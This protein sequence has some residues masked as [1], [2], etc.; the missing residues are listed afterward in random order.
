MRTKYVLMI[1]LLVMLFPSCSQMDLAPEDWYGSNNFWNNEAQVKG[2]IY[3]I[4]KQ[5]RDG[6][7]NYWLMG[8]VRG[9]TLK[10]GTGVSTTSVSMNYVSPFI[11]QGFT[12]DKPGITSWGGFYGRILNVNL[13]IQKVENEC[14]FLTQANR[15]YYLGQ[16]Y[17]I[18]AFYYFWLYRTWGGVPIITDVKVMNGVTTAEPLYTARSTAKA[19]LDFIKADVNKS[20]TLF[21]SNV[22]MTDAKSVWSKFATLMLKAEVYLWSAK[23]TTG[24]QTPATSDLATAETALNNVKNSGLFSLQSSFKNVFS[25]TNKGNGEIIYAL[26]FLDPEA[27]NNVSQYLYDVTFVSNAYTKAGKLMGDT[28]NIKSNLGLQR[29]E[30]DFPFWQAF[31]AKD[32]RRDATLLDFY[33]KD[34]SGNLTING[35]IL[36]KLLGTINSTSVRV[37]ADDIPVYRYADV[38]LMLAEVANK[39]GEDPSSYI[40]AVRARAYGSGYPVYVN[41]SFANNEL[42]ILAER[43]REFVFENK[44]W[45]DLVR[46]QDANGNSLVFSNAPSLLYGRSA[47]ALPQSD[48][49]KIYLPIDVNTLNSDPKLVQTQGY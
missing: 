48:A 25:Y 4:H 49:Y 7:V 38:L 20:E 42:A 11:D 2:Y 15:E 41:S 34:K 17:G 47:A 33:Y 12:K 26:R 1:S 23:V 28:L 5:I 30:Y 13:A 37:Y 21:G 40:N 19:T 39:K 32:T 27:T 8:E 22:T 3:G 46:M 10:L 29:N 18:R 14:S 16:L 36:R 44:R 9:G 45:F 6:N 43:D 31:D 24:D 35:T